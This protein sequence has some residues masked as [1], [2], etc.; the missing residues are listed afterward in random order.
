[1][2]AT[3]SELAYNSASD[4]EDE[5]DWEEVTV[6]AAQPLD[7]YSED[8]PGL[9]TRPIIEVTLEAHPAQGKDKRQYAVLLVPSE[10]AC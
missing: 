6:P 9:S 8:Q 2:S 4:G 7:P 3:T 1:M 10:R 5:F